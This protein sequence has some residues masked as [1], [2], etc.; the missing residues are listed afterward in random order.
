MNKTTRIA[1][2]VETNRAHGRSMLEGISDYALAHT[3]W[4]LEAVK[5]SAFTS[6]SELGRF[7]GFIVRVMEYLGTRPRER[8]I[9]QGVCVP[10]RL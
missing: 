8:P 4:R 6:S 1:M 2:Q 7:D 9:F 5:P 10:R 3:D